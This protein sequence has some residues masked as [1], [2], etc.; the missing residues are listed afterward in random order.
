MAI[1]AG[2]ALRLWIGG[3]ATAVGSATNCTLNIAV[4]TITTRHKDTTGN[5]IEK[6]PDEISGTL[7][8]EAF[9]DETNT[10]FGTIG[11]AVLVGTEIDWRFSSAVGASHKW[12]GK[13]FITSYEENAP[14]DGKATYSVTIETTSTIAKGTV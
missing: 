13:G 12:S 1:V 2:K 6:E 10:T 5:F 11:A 7:T 3:T 8:T 4:S 9:I 14:V